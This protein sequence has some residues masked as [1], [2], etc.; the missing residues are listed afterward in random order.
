MLG[1]GSNMM[2]HPVTGKSIV[3]DGLVLQHNYNSSSVEPLSSGAASFD[4]TSDYIAINA[5]PVDTAD[6]TYCWWSNSTQVSS[7]CI[8]SHG[9]NRTGAFHSN[10]IE[11]GK[12]LLYLH[13]NLYQYWVDTGFADDGKW[14]HWALVID[15]SSMSSCKLYCDG[16]EVAQGARETTGA[17]NSYS[18]MEIGRYDAIEFDGY[19]C[20]FGVWSSHLSQAQV[21]SIMN[22]NYDSLSASEKEDLVSWW[23]LD[24]TTTQLATAVYDNHHGG[25]EL[26]SGELGENMD[27]EDGFG[28]L[29]SGLANGWRSARGNLT[30]NTTTPYQGTSAQSVTNPAGNNGN[31]YLHDSSF[32]GGEVIGA[33]YNVSFWAKNIKGSGGYFQSQNYDIANVDISTTDWTFYSFSALCDSTSGIGLIFY[34]DANNTNDTNGV[35]VDNVSVTRVN[36]NTGT[37]S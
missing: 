6:G 9:N 4:G 20:N 22:K 21:K 19:M 15:V 35:S 25:E 7:Q 17:I 3:R 33:I 12:P 8:F 28:E 23:N 14:H 30:Q 37:L 10:F 29:A 13:N 1:L 16:V 34:T 2:K 31:V 5:K 11:T 26:L 36:G 24:S 27:F 32:S 18:N